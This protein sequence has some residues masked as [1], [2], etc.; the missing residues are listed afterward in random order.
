MA[1]LKE[2]REAVPLALAL[3]GAIDGAAAG[4]QSAA[5]AAA[6]VKIPAQPLSAQS[7]APRSTTGGGGGGGDTATG[8]GERIAPPR[9]VRAV[10]RQLQPR[11]VDWLNEKCARTTF[12]IPN[13]RNP[14]AARDN[15]MVSL[16]GWDCS[17]ELH[18]VADFYDPAD[19]DRLTGADLTRSSRST[20]GSGNNGGPINPRAAIGSRNDQEIY[21]NAT[22]DSQGGSSTR[23]SGPTPVSDAT[24][25]RALDEQTRLL[26]EIRDQG[27][28]DAGLGRRVGGR[29]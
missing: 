12:S 14:H 4:L 9:L 29:P 19:W 15:D 24:T 8:G 11:S 22:G 1:L 18:M 21:V 10:N 27:R 20:K 6:R 28:Q 3:E 17:G 26:R 23:P 7:L 5:E 25:A 13:P 16:G 2:L